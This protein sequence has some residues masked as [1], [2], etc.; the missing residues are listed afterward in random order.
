MKK[1]RG[2]SGKTRT[3]QLLFV[4]L[5]MGLLAVLPLAA[6][7]PCTDCKS[8]CNTQYCKDKAKC[9]QI[10]AGQA[11]EACK[12]AAENVRVQCYVMCNTDGYCNDGDVEDPPPCFV[13]GRTDTCIRTPLN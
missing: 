10:P 4:V 8:R 12:Y 11:R 1:T 5:A 2:N 6:T 7:D 13:S 3:R 9:Q